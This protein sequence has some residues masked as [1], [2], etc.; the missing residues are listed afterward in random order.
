MNPRLLPVACLVLTTCTCLGVAAAGVDYENPSGV[1]IY[2]IKLVDR[3]AKSVWV[4]LERNGQRLKFVPSTQL[5]GRWFDHPVLASSVEV[6]EC[7]V[8]PGLL[9]EKLA[10]LKP[11][12][13]SPSSTADRRRFLASLA[14]GNALTASC[15]VQGTESLEL[16]A[17]MDFSRGLRFNVEFVEVNKIWNL[18]FRLIPTAGVPGGLGV[19]LLSSSL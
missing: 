11:E 10:T 14:D 5:E 15:R 3:G 9:V 4:R 7:G 8:A 12:S 1:D 16:P 13:I 19:E 2:K 6:P 17:G 18:T